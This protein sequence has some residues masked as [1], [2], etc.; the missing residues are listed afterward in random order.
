MT[1]AAAG[2]WILLFA[3]S[4]ATPVPTNNS[5]IVAT[6]GTAAAAGSP[7][8]QPPAVIDD[9]TTTGETLDSDSAK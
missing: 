2:L 6:N 4:H 7:G 9:G 8:E 5:T 1:C 3:L